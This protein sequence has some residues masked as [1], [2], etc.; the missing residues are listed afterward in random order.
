MEVLEVALEIQEVLEEL[1]CLCRTC[2]MRCMPNGCHTHFVQSFI[3]PRP[4]TS[5]PLCLVLLRLLLSSYRSLLELMLSQCLPT[6]KPDMFVR[7]FSFSSPKGMAPQGAPKRSPRESK[8]PQDGSR[9]PRGPQKNAKTSQ[10]ALRWVQADP[11]TSYDRKSSP[12]PPQRV[13]GAS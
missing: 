3:R 13:P 1:C 9:C 11:K 6:R 10:D 4:P 7:I 5:P 12:R 2:C 8:T